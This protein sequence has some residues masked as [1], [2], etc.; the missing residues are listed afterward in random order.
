[1]A[2]RIIDEIKI[3]KR[4]R[5][6]YYCRVSTTSFDQENSF[7]NQV[8][9]YKEYKARHPECDFV[10]IYT[11]EGVS[12]RTHQSKRDGFNRMLEDC[13]KKKI[14]KIIVKEF[15]RFSRNTIVG[16]SSLNELKRLGVSVYFENNNIDTGIIDG[17]VFLTMTN[18]MTETES[19]KISENVKWSYQHRF[20]TG[21]FKHFSAPYGYDAIQGELI[22]N[23]KEANVVRKIFDLAD[24]GCTAH[25]IAQILNNEKAPLGTSCKRWLPNKVTTILRNERYKGDLLLQ[26]SITFEGADHHVRNKGFANQYYVEGTHA[27]IVSREQFDRVNR[28]TRERAKNHTAKN[29]LTKKSYLFSGKIK[30]CKCGQSLVRKVTGKGKSYERTKWSC[31]NYEISRSLCNMKRIREDE[32]VNSIN[33]LIVFIGRNDCTILKQYIDSVVESCHAEQSG[34]IKEMQQKIKELKKQKAY[35]ELQSQGTVS[36]FLMQKIR[37]VTLNIEEI[38]QRINESESIINIFEVGKTQL[39]IDE[40]NNKNEMTVERFV[41]DYIKEIVIYENTIRFKIK[42]EFELIQKRNI[43]SRKKG[44]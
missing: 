19:K 9:Y 37:E 17:D 38:E 5:V 18:F 43:P 41:M 31:L 27:P 44:E 12:G 2:V 1:M 24:Q 10:G 42:G 11:D 3:E 4:L 22:E 6:A 7:E 16:L 21:N 34:S 35:L 15:S 14:D 8:N 13:R 20:K 30:C 26:K 29:G 28:V 39:L 40:L 33:E 32:I 25:R 23:E 36:A